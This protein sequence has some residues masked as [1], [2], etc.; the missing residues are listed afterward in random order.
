MFFVFTRVFETDRN[1]L[2]RKGEKGL[3]GLYNG[4]ET[5]GSE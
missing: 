1:L 4:G 3:Q 5:G 2:Q